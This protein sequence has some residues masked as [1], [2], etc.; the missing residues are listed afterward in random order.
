MMD[1]SHQAVLEGVALSAPTEGVSGTGTGRAPATSPAA[2]RKNILNNKVDH[3]L[4]SNNVGLMCK[5]YTSM[6]VHVQILQ[7]I[8]PVHDYSTVIKL[9]NIFTPP[10]H[11]GLSVGGAYGRDSQLN[12]GYMH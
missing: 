2:D 1:Y 12:C 8:I 11:V 6:W 5:H 9:P 10:L 7:S 4:S 3:P